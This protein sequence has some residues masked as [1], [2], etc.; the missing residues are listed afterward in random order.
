MSERETT[1]AAL[2]A[3]AGLSIT[4]GAAW[5]S[6]GAGLVTAG[7]LLGLWSWLVL[8]DDDDEAAQ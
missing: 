1:F 4:A 8:A 3:V 2:L 6:I 7:V 5:F